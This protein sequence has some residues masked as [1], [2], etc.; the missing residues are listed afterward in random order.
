MPNHGSSLIK[1]P[2]KA[3]V[4]RDGQAY[5]THGASTA[6][7]YVVPRS[8]GPSS[9]RTGM[10]L[11]CRDHSQLRENSHEKVRKVQPPI[12]TQRMWHDPELSSLAVTPMTSLQRRRPPII[13][14]QKT[15]ILKSSSTCMVQAGRLTPFR[16]TSPLL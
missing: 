9:L 6:P 15:R 4:L 1:F 11:K 12:C 14:F 3:L 13:A 8:Q 7:L 5:A 10:F 2:V 16:L